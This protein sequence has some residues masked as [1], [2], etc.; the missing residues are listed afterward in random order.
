[1]PV[2]TKCSNQLIK[3]LRITHATLHSVLSACI[4]CFYFESLVAK[5]FSWI[6]C[7]SPGCLHP[8]IVGKRNMWCDWAKWVAIANTLLIWRHS[9][10]KQLFISVSC[11]CFCNHSTAQFQLD[12]FFNLDVS[13]QS[14]K[15]K[16][17][18]CRLILLNRIIHIDLKSTC[19]IFKIF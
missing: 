5:E 15:L 4:K 1:M 14:E 16:L 8:S 6:C 7:Q 11:Y 18:N 17:I 9:Q 3:P 12:F 10:P 19:Y 2:K 13:N